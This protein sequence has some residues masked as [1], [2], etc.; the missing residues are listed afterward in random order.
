MILFLKRTFKQLHFFLTHRRQRIFMWLLLRYSGRKRFDPLAIHTDGMHFSLPDAASFVW[1]YKDIFTDEN[2]LFHTQTPEPIILDCGANVGSSVMYFKHLYPNSQVIAYEADPLIA[3]YLEQNVA[4]NKLT[5]VQ[6]VNKALWIH[7]QGIKMASEGADGGGIFAQGQ[8]QQLPSVRL[9]NELEKYTHIDM[10]KIDIEG[11][12]YE[13]LADCADRLEH[14]AH[15]F[16]EFHSYMGESQRLAEILT[17]VTK[18]GFRYFIRHEADRM[19]PFVNRM[20]RSNPA[21]DLQLNIF[22]YRN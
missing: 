9:R 8:K 20:N 5:G 21:M 14:V 18:A 2:Y 6:I 15:L 3:R 13:V 1:Q 12:E 19:Q 16:I 22:A 10:L 4:S 11:A 7:N 17:I